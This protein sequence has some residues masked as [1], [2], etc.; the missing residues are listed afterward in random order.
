MFQLTFM[1]APLTVYLI[2]HF[3]G[4]GQYTEIPLWKFFIASLVDVHATVLIV[5]A[6]MQTSITSVMVIED[7]SIPSALML[8]L[9]WLGV[10]YHTTH[11]VAICICLCGI[12]IGFTNDFLHLDEA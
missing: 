8:S 1:Y 11:Y 2:Y 10:K 5:G 7:F 6:Y 9:F 4:K 3:K 12:S